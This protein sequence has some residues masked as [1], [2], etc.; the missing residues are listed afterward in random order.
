MDFRLRRIDDYCPRKMWKSVQ[1]YH[2]MYGAN[3]PESAATHLQHDQMWK[4]DSFHCL[5]LHSTHH[6]TW[7]IMVF[8]KNEEVRVPNLWPF[9]ISNQISKSEVP[10]KFGN[11]NVP[12]HHSLLSTQD[13]QG[14]LC[15]LSYIQIWDHAILVNL[16][17]IT[18][19]FYQALCVKETWLVRLTALRTISRLHR[20]VDH[21]VHELGLLAR[22]RR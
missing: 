22:S 13:M 3:M 17:F 11:P 18:V 10:S 14:V 16:W 19:A 8:K 12:N 2:F 7:M 6:R 15:W 21:V 1:W 5:Q 20:M 4:P 9:H